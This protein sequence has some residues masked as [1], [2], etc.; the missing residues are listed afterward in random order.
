MD[1]ID[2]QCRLE[3]HFRELRAR[4]S[5]EVGEHPIFA[6]EHGLDEREVREVAM[7]IRAQILSGE[8]CWEHR[9]PWVVYATE[10]GY[11]YSGDEYWQ[12]FEEKTP[13]WLARGERH[14]I[15]RCFR[16]FQQRYRG[17]EPTGPWSRHFSIICWP[18]THA[19][20]PQDLQRQ[21]AK[22]LYEVRHVLTSDVLSSPRNLGEMIAG[23]SWG[24]SSRFQQ[25]TQEPLLIG[26]IASALLLEGQGEASSLILPVT[27]HRLARDLD[28]ERRS[29]SWMKDARG[30]AKR[31]VRFQRGTST[32]GEASAE[33]ENDEDQDRQHKRLGAEP[34]LLLRPKGDKQWEVSLELPDF[35]HVLTRFPSLRE[36]LV[37][38]Q[39]RV[40]GSSGRP[41][42]RGRLLYGPQRILLRKWPP[43]DQPLLK[44]EQ[45]T[46]ELDFLL[47]TECYLRAGPTW[48]FKIASDGLAYELHSAR[49]RAGKKYLLVSREPLPA[50]DHQFVTPVSIE[51]EGV[52]GLLFDLPDALTPE[53]SGLLD[54]LGIQMAGMVEIWPAGLVP[55][56]WDGE[57]S[58]EW[59]STDTPCVGVRAD[60][61]IQS[62]AAQLNNEALELKPSRPGEP[63]FID[64]SWLGVGQ[65]VLSVSARGVSADSE[66]AP[67]ILNIQIREPRSWVPRGNSQSALMVVVDPG[68]P[69][70]E[71]LWQGDVEIEIHGPRRRKIECIVALYRK[72]DTLPHFKRELPP[73]KIPVS[74][75][76]W[77]EFF[78]AQFRNHRDFQNAYDLA[79]RCEVHFR[80][81][82]LGGYTLSVEREFVPLRWV[83]SQSTEDF[84]L[85]VINDTGELGTTEVRSFDFHAPDQERILDATP[86]LKKE[87]FEAETGLYAA[88][89]GDYRKAIV[90]PPTTVH[91][92]KDLAPKP[93]LRSW[94][95]TR[96]DIL[97]LIGLFELW[98]SARLTGGGNIL[99]RERRRR[100]L[101]ALLEETVGL[102]CGKHW[103]KVE[104]GFQGSTEDGG[105]EAVRRAISNARIGTKLA[106]D[107]RSLVADLVEI[108]AT[109]RVL[110]FARLAHRYLGL[111]APPFSGTHGLMPSDINKLRLSEGARRAAL[112]VH[113]KPEGLHLPEGPENP[114]WLSE[115]AL[116]LASNPVGLISWAGEYVEEGLQRLL[117]GPEL[118]RAAR[119]LV[120]VSRQEYGWESRRPGELYEG[121]DWQ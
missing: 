67:A 109:K 11:L 79:H 100:V 92:F 27:L 25:L 106:C 7:A 51:C 41:L 55:A 70:L 78:E 62:F 61:I 71:Q 60:H 101:E 108:P 114:L 54:S 43:D 94:R 103:R 22:V 6:L 93:K 72:G 24:T 19:I 85:R 50:V 26:Q 80:G 113:E 119:F 118:A 110:E 48:L 83:V 5:A 40:A 120:L 9:L 121:W 73:L 2:W 20:V 64:L 90:V 65:H 96:S 63:V 76:E 53:I 30:H 102:I 44:F 12:T 23:R 47:K 29:R 3:A 52:D 115:L 14:W 8:P 13:G 112:V 34:R 68:R 1:L 111:P 49:V 39:C 91:A 4:R 28:R 42:A 89:A 77:E 33:G 86:F 97:E 37:N 32:G 74:A 82:E 59:L 17:A 45:S 38:S 107:L 21:L 99:A 69:T 84:C 81:G 88:Y 98:A 10:F 35:S 116:R 16:D 18:I 15:R 56:R 57:G 46:A 105:L 75:R 95:R 31:V 87:G 104:R 58:A 117:D 66:A 36:P